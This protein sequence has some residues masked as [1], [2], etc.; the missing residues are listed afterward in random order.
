M[1]KVAIVLGLATVAFWG[2]V[3]LTLLVA[4]FTWNILRFV[5]PGAVV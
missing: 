3:F 5:V 4:R 2:A 1:G